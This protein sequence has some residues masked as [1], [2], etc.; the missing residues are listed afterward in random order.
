MENGKN[1]PKVTGLLRLKSEELQ[2]S[3][4]EIRL[5]GS[6]SEVTTLKLIHELEVHQMELEMQNE[7]L[8]LAKEQ[9]EQAIE[10]YTKLYDYAPSGYFTLSQD[11]KVTEA[12]LTGAHMLGKVRSSVLNSQFGFFISDATKNLFNDFLVKIFKSNVRELCEVNFITNDHKSFFGC[13]YGVVAT[14]PSLCN[15]TLIDITERKEAEAALSNSKEKYSDLLNNLVEGIL[16]YAP[17]SSIVLSNPKASVLL[18][19]SENQIRGKQLIDL[20]LKFLN[21]SYLPLSVA[22]YPFNQILANKKPLKNYTVGVK[23][24]HSKDVEFLL[25]NGFPVVD[26]NGEVTEI[27]ISF[28]DIT[29]IKL[30]QKEVIKAKYFAEKA[31]KAKSNFLTNMSH[32][33]RTPLNGIVGFTDLLIKTDLNGDQ[34]EYVNIV[35]E[36]AIILMEIINDVLDFSKIESG[37]L[38]LN[39]EEID[40]FGLTSQVITLF[41]HQAKL[42]NIDLHLTVESNVPQFIFADS[43]R[44]KQ[45]IVNLISNALKFTEEGFIQLKIKEIASDDDT[46]SA[47]KFSV[48]DTGM[49]IKKQNQE[50]I[51]YSFVQEDLSTTRKFGGTGLGLAISNQLLELMNSKLLLKSKYGKGSN[52][53]FFIDFKKSER[54][55]DI[56]VPFLQHKD[57]KTEPIKEFLD[58][59]RILIVEDN[60][61]NMLLAKKMIKKI[62]PNCIIFEATDG[63]K[64]VKLY[65]KQKLDIILMDIQMPKKNGFETTIAIRNLG[66]SCATPII[67]LT[68]GILIEEKE[69]CLKSGMNDYISKPINITDL[70]TVLNKWIKN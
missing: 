3:K 1:R 22:E 9:A 44:L 29:E 27:V 54:R 58:N 60:R 55:E 63:K 2:K 5:Y 33:I 6:P 23:K 70:E 50:K 12:N 51:F 46:I 19:L 13:L 10:K 32:E 8:L 37:N 28:I 39:I 59:T 52:F 47:I 16:V 18:G 14:D 25:V 53:H 34:F 56:L 49:G 4:N 36:S 62:I 26:S 43:V 20:D 57:N 30:M 48:K 31:N 69:K 35:N 11:G 40:L 66:R 68:A 61:I 24:P 17:D 45:I 21:E 42:K 7:E 41:K 15:V 64:A 38:E 67:A 65:K